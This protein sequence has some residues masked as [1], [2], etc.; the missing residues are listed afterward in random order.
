MENNRQLICFVLNNMS[1]SKKAIKNGIYGTITQIIIFLLKF[2][3]RRFF[4]LYL[5]IEYLGFKSLF[6]NVFALF[7]VSELGI[8][9]IICYQ[10][11]GAIAKNDKNEINKLMSIYRLFYTI[12]GIFVLV[13]GLLCNFVLPYIITNQTVSW[14]YLRQVYI[15]MLISTLSTYFLSYR[16]SLYIASQKEYICMS[17]SVVV[18]IAF[19]IIKLLIIYIHKDF[20]L[21][22]IF[23]ILKSVVLNL[24]IYIYA[25]VIF[26]YLND[27]IGICWKDIKERRIF[28]DIKN[29]LYGKVA[30]VIYFGTDNILISKLFGINLVA[31]Y[32][33]YYLL[34]TSLRSITFNKY[35]G[36][37][38]PSV[39]NFLH[40]ETNTNEIIGLFNNIDLF[41]H[42]CGIIFSLGFCLFA[43]PVIYYWLGPENLFQ[44]DI[45][46]VYCIYIYLEISFEVLNSFRSAYGEFEFDKKYFMYAAIFNIILSIAF[47]RLFGISGII[48]GTIVGFIFIAYGRG[49]FIYYRI[50][51]IDV[52]K[53]LIKHIF[54]TIKFVVLFLITLFVSSSLD[55]SLIS[56]FYRALFF[57]FSIIVYFFIEYKIN[58]EF[59]SLKEYIERVFLQYEKIKI[60]YKRFNSK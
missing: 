23:D 42:C 49:K 19:S 40:S 5:S 18:E 2:I 55:F 14:D 36:A 25:K 51:M 33:N 31:I 47:S 44:F 13:I 29:L 58:K 52:I 27:N 46:M 6:G 38:N 12:I 10:L 34:Y 48:M 56:L 15:L 60:F 50:I 20:I 9:S 22:L 17:I 43:N 41:N 4:V 30:G 54:L 1:N 26:T 45:V 16:Q 24:T 8:S 59:Y 32:A 35:I 53:Y 39:A 11:Y 28:F 21:Y 37:I 7:S 3:E 57:F